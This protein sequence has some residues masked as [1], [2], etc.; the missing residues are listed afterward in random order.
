MDCIGRMLNK[1]NVQTV[2]KPLKKIGQILRNPKDQRTPF[3]STEVYKIL[4][5][6]LS[7]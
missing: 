6:K 2:F 1:Y 4:T 7:F 3:S 5:K